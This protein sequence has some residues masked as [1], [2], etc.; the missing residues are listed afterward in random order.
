MGAF[1]SVYAVCE[2][3]NQLEFQSKSG[4]CEFRQYY[5]NNAP[6]DVL[7]DV[8]RHSPLCC[9]CGNW[10]EVDIEKRQLAIVPQPSQEGPLLVRDP[11]GKILDQKRAMYEGGGRFFNYFGKKK[12]GEFDLDYLKKCFRRR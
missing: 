6:L 2:C 11:D 7:C 3:G 1:D 12:M 5:L 9:D 10:L 8:N 4:D